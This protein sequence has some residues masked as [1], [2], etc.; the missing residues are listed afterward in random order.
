MRM[1]VNNQCTVAGG[2]MSDADS[3]PTPR[4]FAGRCIDGF[5]RPP[6]ECLVDGDRGPGERCDARAQCVPR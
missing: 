2:C 1:Y 4:C 6:T 5:C 3:P